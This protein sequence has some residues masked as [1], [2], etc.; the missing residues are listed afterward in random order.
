MPFKSIESAPS[1]LTSLGLF[2]VLLSK[3]PGILAL[4]SPNSHSSRTSLHSSLHSSPSNISIPHDQVTASSTSYYANGKSFGNVKTEIE[5]TNLVKRTYA[6]RFLTRLCVALPLYLPQRLI[7]NGLRFPLE[8]HHPFPNQCRLLRSP[9]LRLQR[10]LQRRLSIFQ[11]VGSS[12][13]TV[14]IC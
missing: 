12:P 6:W 10:R 3:V 7:H 2:L 11:P 14:K 5:F 13:M 1:P 8:S 9:R 4:N